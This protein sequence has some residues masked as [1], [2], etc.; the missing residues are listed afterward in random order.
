MKESEEFQY[1]FLIMNTDRLDKKG[2]HWW[3]F[4]DIHQKKKYFYLIVLVLV[5]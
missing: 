4:L 2:T 3:S 1:P 5:V